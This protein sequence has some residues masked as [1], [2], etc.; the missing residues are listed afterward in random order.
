MKETLIV[1]FGQVFKGK[2]PIVPCV[3][4]GLM[5]FVVLRSM[6]LKGMV[7]F[8]QTYQQGECQIVNE[9]LHLHMLTFPFITL[10]DI[11]QPSTHG[12]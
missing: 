12:K 6:I 11:F 5:K 7:H 9:G 1:L 3:H 2:R 4:F 8:H 10:C